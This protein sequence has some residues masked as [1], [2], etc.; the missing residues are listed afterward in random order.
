[1]KN[2]NSLY[3]ITHNKNISKKRIFYSSSETISS[4]PSG[5]DAGVSTE[6]SS[7]SLSDSSF[8]ASYLI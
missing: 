8:S 2:W 4:G 3:N 7:D 5:I 1:L 6:F